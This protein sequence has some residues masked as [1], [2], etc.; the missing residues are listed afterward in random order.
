MTGERLA[1]LNHCPG[2]RKS[3]D[4]HQINAVR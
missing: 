1:F 2:I 3:N 4:T